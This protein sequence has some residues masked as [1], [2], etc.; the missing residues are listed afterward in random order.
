MRSG[1]YISKT[2]LVAILL[3]AATLSGAFLFGA[4]LPIKPSSSAAEMVYCPL[5]RKL[6]PVN[7]PKPAAP[8]YSLNEICA[9]EFEKSIFTLA[10][11]ESAK[12]NFSSISANE[13]EDLV[14]NFWQKGKSAFDSLPNAPNAPQEFTAKNS[15]SAINF[16]SD[17]KNKIVW[18]ATENF[19]FQSKP[20]PPTTQK[21]F[22]FE[23]QSLKLLDESSNQ[24]SPRAPPPVSL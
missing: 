23:S 4:L 1:F 20:R 15:F 10:I 22:A 21:I 5:T 2:Y 18:L 13:F 7:P 12:L 6:Q 16:G 19:A 24:T 3:L 8:V 11:L 14:F 9:A 17:Y